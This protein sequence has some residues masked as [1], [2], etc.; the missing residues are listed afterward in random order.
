V[1]SEN[2][3]YT[4]EAFV[5]FLNHLGENGILTMSRWFFKGRPMETLRLTGVAAAALGELG[6]RNPG[7]HIMVVKRSTWDWA[8]RVGELRDGVGTL[9]VKRTPWLPGEVAHIRAVAEELRF[10]VVYSPGGENHPD[11]T[12]LIDEGTGALARTYPVDISPPTDNRPFFFYMLR[13]GDALGL[14]FRS[15]GVEQGVV[16]NNVRAIFVLMG[17]F[18]IVLLLT[19]VFFVAPAVTM[20]GERFP[21]SKESTLFLVYFFCLGLG[22]LL[23]EIPLVQRFILY[24]GHPVHALTVVLFSLLVGSGVGSLL[25]P[26][27]PM[28]RFWIPM[29]LLCLAVPA[30]MWLIPGV[31]HAT[32]GVSFA[33]RVGIALAVLLPLAFL[34]GMPFPMGIRALGPEREG[35]VPWVWGVNGATSVCASVL[36]TLL[37]IS[38]G[39]SV[40]LLLGGLAYAAA[41]LLMLPLRWREAP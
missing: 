41:L 26:R 28:R 30:A 6:A 2:N 36:A 25:S 38:F 39:F 11:F 23:V 19:V 32:I 35:M 9:L 10:D 16:Q 27:V 31:F 8:Y 40:V 17:L 22:Y 4:K 20:R 13:P 33:G 24:L 15:G 34:M 18:L 7:D 29:V 21:R 37:A 5:E 3:L 1:L 12:R 14:L